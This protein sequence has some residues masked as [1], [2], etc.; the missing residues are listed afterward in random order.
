MPLM[1][2]KGTGI[3]CIIFF[4]PIQFLVCAL[5]MA[6]WDLYGKLKNKQLH[7]LWNLD[8]TKKP[9]N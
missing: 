2:R 5:D 9:G 3:T 6:G 7:T 4:P 1:T 8:I